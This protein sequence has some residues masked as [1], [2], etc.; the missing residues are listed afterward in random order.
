MHSLHDV[1]RPVIYRHRLENFRLFTALYFFVFFLIEWARG[2][3]GERKKIIPVKIIA[4]KLRWPKLFVLIFHHEQLHW[5]QKD[6]KMYPSNK[7]RIVFLH[8]ERLECE[9]KSFSRPAFYNLW[10]PLVIII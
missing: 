2:K 4:V 8:K 9:K 1:L 7:L 10:L 5:M 3:N 6:P